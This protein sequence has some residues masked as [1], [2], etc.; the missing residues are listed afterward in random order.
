MLAGELPNVDLTDREGLSVSWADSTFPFWNAVFLTE[1]LASEASLRKRV[2]QAAAYMRARR[3]WG[4][5][6][7]CEE[8]LGSS[9]KESLPAVMAEEGFDFAL[10]V[11]GMAGEMLP[12]RAP[13]HPELKIERVA[14]E[15]QLRLFRC[16]LCGVWIPSGVGARWFGWIKTLE[17][18]CPCVLRLRKERS[19]FCCIG[20]GA[21]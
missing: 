18:E 17:R 10:P 7:I 9:A 1:Q 19:G 13:K 6:Y 20:R 12:V 21:Q 2:Q 5:V 4:L 3:R 11:F 16:E 14:T 15:A 8:Y